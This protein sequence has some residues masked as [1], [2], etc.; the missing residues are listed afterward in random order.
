M[1]EYLVEYPP[2]T[3]LSPFTEGDT[4][5]SCSRKRGIT[6]MANLPVLLA[7][8]IIPGVFWVVFFHRQDRYDPEP[9]LP[10][11]L[12]FVLG[13]AMVI[14][15]GLLEAPFRP[16]FVNPPNLFTLFILSV[17][18]VGLVEEY[19]K[20]WVVR[21]F[22][23]NSRV[24]NEPLDGVIYAVTAGLGFAAAENVLYA[25]MYGVGISL[26]RGVLTTLAHAAFSSFVGLG[27]GLAKFAP[28]PGSLVAR[29]L[30]VAIALHGI[31]DFLLLSGILSF[32]MV[33][34]VVGAL[35]LALARQIREGLR[36]S[37]FRH[38]PVEEE[39]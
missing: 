4:C 15:A 11:A 20:F 26:I 18:V 19:A 38:G 3:R 32:R 30:V 5:H 29:G 16:F 12:M 1:L 7:V 37:P 34:V 25:A 24:F 6:D 2:H 31:Y 27:L 21:R 14:P 35:Y 17:F 13:A 22:V 33:I 23:F 8:S 28:R 10:M 39:E 36:I 9:V